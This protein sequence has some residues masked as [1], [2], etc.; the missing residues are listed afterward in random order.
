MPETAKA[1]R[2]VRGLSDEARW[3]PALGPRRAGYCARILGVEG[4][5]TVG[6]LLGLYPRDYQDRRN[7]CR[8]SDLR[9]GTMATFYGQIS[10]PAADKRTPTGKTVT[11][12]PVR[13]GTGTVLLNWFNQPYIKKKLRIG[14]WHLI[15]GKMERFGPEVRITQPD[16]EKMEGT[17]ALSGGRIVPIYPLTNGIQQ[18]ALRSAI[19]QALDLAARFVEETLPAKILSKYRLQGAQLAAESIHF[20]ATPQALEMA[21]RRLKFEE[22][23][24]IQLLLAARKAHDQEKPGIKLVIDEPIAAE[25][26]AMMPFEPTGAQKRVVREIF[27]D[28]VRPT[29]M[30]RLLQGDVGSGKTV[31][32]AIAVVAAVRNGCQ[33]ALMAPT[34]ILAE[35][36]AITFKNLLEPLGIPV[37]L[38]TGSVAGRERAAIMEGLSTGDLQVVV[39]THALIQEPVRFRR[40]GLVIVDEQHRFGVEQRMKIQEQGESGESPHVLVMTATPIP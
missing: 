17:Q 36:H 12:I 14:D 24:L 32:A 28:L 40:L 34:E 2:L 27:R 37:R 18:P 22:L 9:P 33:V 3:L 6:D 38:L 16:M 25:I 19:R 1:P 5:I 11:Q 26:R 7:L 4:H 31:V 30:N 10:G 20:P 8:I 15:T 23:F 35:Q 39:G 13:D 21:Q 29:P